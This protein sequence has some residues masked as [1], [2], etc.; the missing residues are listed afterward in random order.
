[1]KF[2][3]AIKSV[4]TLALGFSVVGCQLPGG[5]PG[6]LVDP[7]KALSDLTAVGKALLNDTISTIQSEADMEILGLLT[8][9]L[10]LTLPA[11]YRV[12]VAEVRAGGNTV[13]TG[14]GGSV[15]VKR[16][17]GKETSVTRGASGSVV[18]KG[19]DGGETN[20]TTR[21]D[22]AV[23]VKGPDNKETTVT[24][25]ADGAVVVK[26]PDNKETTITRGADNRT[27]IKGPN[28]KE[29]TLDVKPQTAVDKLPMLTGD[30]IKN[31]KDHQENFENR[32]KVRDRLTAVKANIPTGSSSRL[33]EPNQ[34]GSKNI[35]VK[36]EVKTKGGQSLTHSH[37]R[38]VDASGALVGDTFKNDRGY[39]NGMSSTTDRNVVVAANGT[40]TESFTKTITKGDKKKTISW[41][42]TVNADGSSEAV[43]KI[44]QFNGAIVDI[45][46]SKTA[47]GKVTTV[48]TNSASKVKVEVVKDDEAGTSAATK[49]VST[50]DNKTISE[51]TVADIEAVEPSDN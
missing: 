5:L 22:G 39:K 28:G 45:T 47:E 35:Y 42:R 1:M 38:T 11:V 36:T 14:P 23:V 13:T 24:K 48:S 21:A 50:A 26:G 3:V 19:P 9:D 6:N 43:G 20:V 31:L 10:T 16:P 25:R 7:S 8:G 15:T 30:A 2:N 27:V 12:A 18:V 40:R 51:E 49:I 44:T 33:E 29:I 4:L 37:V 17:D 32:T 46:I 41:T 34:D